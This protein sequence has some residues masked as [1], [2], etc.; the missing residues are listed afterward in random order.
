MS[1]SPAQSAP[2]RSPWRKV[3]LA[4]SLTATAGYVDGVGYLLLFHVFTANMS[5]NTIATGLYLVQ[6]KWHLFF[7]RFW[8]I[9]MFMLGLTAA[10][11]LLEVGRRRKLRRLLSLSLA[12]EAV[13]LALLLGLGLHLGSSISPQSKP[14]TLIAVIMVFFAATAMGIQN[15]SLRHVGALSIHTTHVTGTLTTLAQKFVGFGFWF[16]DSVRDGSQGEAGSAVRRMWRQQ[17][18]WQVMI[19]S[20][21]WLFYLAGGAAGAAASIAWGMRSIAVPLAVVAGALLA[22]LIHPFPVRRRM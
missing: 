16:Y 10:A 6:G 9:P 8:P 5:G 4:L 21:I 14:P 20:G 1:D 19:L 17:R 15:A 7:H 11:V 12:T 3:V 22:D 13:L 18:F 2:V